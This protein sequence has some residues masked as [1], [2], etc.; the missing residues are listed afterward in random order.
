MDLLKVKFAE[1][2]KYIM[3][4]SDYHEKTI[5]ITMPSHIGSLDGS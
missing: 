3:S 4:K 5:N 2:D 1:S